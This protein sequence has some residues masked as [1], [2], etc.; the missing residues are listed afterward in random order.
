[1]DMKLEVAVLP[2]ADVDRA[3]DFYKKLGWRLDMDATPARTT[4]SCS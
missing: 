1:M 4:G 2:V 3:K